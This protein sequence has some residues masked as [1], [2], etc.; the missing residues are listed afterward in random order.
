MARRCAVYRHDTE[1]RTV[2][3]VMIAA[4]SQSRW[5]EAQAAELAVVQYEREH[6]RR[7][8]EHIFD[9][10]GISFDQK[11]KSIVEI[12]C[13]AYPA[14]AFCGEPNNG[15]LIVEPLYFQSLQDSGI[16]W[17][18]MAFEDMD[19][20]PCDEVWIYNALQHVRDPE[21]VIAK[22]KQSAPVIRFFEPVDYPTCVYHPH[23]FTQADFERWFN[24]SVKRYTDRLPGFFDADCVYGTWA[25]V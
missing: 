7:S 23:T 21:L 11:G 14:L 1:R 12:G 6:S 20:L 18:R 5:Q 10:L 4:I 15:M 22:A 13:G 16:P 3:T 24:G 19:L 17:A 25:N 9:Y 8:Y 2:Q